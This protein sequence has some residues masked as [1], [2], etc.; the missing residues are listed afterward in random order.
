MA[1][2]DSLRKGGKNETLLVIQI[3]FKNKKSDWKNSDVFKDESFCGGT[4]NLY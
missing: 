2:F 4:F 3:T 1:N